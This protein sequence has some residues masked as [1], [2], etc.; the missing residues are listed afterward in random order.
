MIACHAT[1]AIFIIYLIWPLTKLKQPRT[2]NAHWIIIVASSKLNPDPLKPYFLRKVIRS[3]NPMNIITLMSWKSVQRRDITFRCWQFH[4][5]EVAFVY[6]PIYSVPSITHAHTQPAELARVSLFDHF[7]LFHKKTDKQNKKLAIIG[8]K[9][10]NCQKNKCKSRQ[11]ICDCE[12]N[13]MFRF[14]H[15]TR[16]ISRRAY[17]LCG[18]EI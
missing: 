16:F 3:P 14:S 15:S 11:T 12:C 8:Y 17:N 2:K 4:E 18:S 13:S 1:R 5:R 9:A 7:S 6:F 10:M